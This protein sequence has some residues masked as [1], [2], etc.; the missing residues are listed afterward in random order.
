MMTFPLGSVNLLL[1]LCELWCWGM[2]TVNQHNNYRISAAGP[3][4]SLSRGK[5]VHQMTAHP[6]HTLRHADL[7]ILWLSFSFTLILTQTNTTFHR[8]NKVKNKVGKEKKK[9]Q[10]LAKGSVSV[11]SSSPVSVFHQKYEKPIK[12]QLPIWQ[13]SHR[14]LGFFQR[15]MAPSSLC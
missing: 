4:K 8:S 10:N 15:L 7:L 2:S 12:V 5:T 3:T 9:S 14:E 6:E 1:L 11:S 13:H